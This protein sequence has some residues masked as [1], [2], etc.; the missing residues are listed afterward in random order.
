MNRR[1]AFRLVGT[2]IGGSGERLFLKPEEV[3]GFKRE[4]P[5]VAQ[6]VR[7]GVE[8]VSQWTAQRVA[9]KRC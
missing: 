2:D 1:D 3:L 4:K 6:R 5:A 9:L 8:K 7:L